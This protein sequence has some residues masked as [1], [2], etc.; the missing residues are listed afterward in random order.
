MIRT[1]STM[2]ALASL[3][4][5]I[6]LSPVLAAQSGQKPVQPPETS[7]PVITGKVMDVDSDGTARLQTPDGQV[8]HVPPYQMRGERLQWGERATCG[9]THGELLCERE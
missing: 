5:L 2:V 8:Y 1:L 9:L 4:G 6:S 3:G 7:L